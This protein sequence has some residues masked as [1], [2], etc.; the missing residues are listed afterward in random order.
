TQAQANAQKILGHPATARIFHL[1]LEQDNVI[2]TLKVF[3]GEPGYDTVKP[4]AITAILHGEGD[5][6]AP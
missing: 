3:E 2:T 4:L 1:D 6:S 5:K